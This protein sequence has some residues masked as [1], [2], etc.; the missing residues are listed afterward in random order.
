MKARIHMNI[1]LKTRH[2]S[3]FAPQ[4][5]AMI[6]VAIASLAT[7]CA[8]SQQPVEINLIQAPR[9]QQIRAGQPTTVWSYSGTA[10]K[11]TRQT[12]TP[13]PNS[14]LGPTIRVWTGQQVSINLTNLIDEPS[15]THWHGLDVPE[16]MDGHPSYAIPFGETFAYKFHVINRAGTY[17]YHPHPHMRT[18]AQVQMGLAG[19]LI[20]HDKEEEELGL[21]SGAFDVPLVIQDRTFDAN[22]QFVYNPNMM[23]GFFGDTICVNGK[24]NYVHPT[25]STVHRLR[26]LNGSNARIYKLAFTDDIPMVVIGN[27]GGLLAKPEVKPYVMLSPGER[28]E[29]WA[30]FGGKSVGTQITLRSLAFSG[31][32]LNQGQAFDVMRFQINRLVT[33]KLRLPEVL[34]KIIPYQL[35]DAVNLKNPKTYPIDMI[36]GGGQMAFRLNNRLFEMDAV[37]PNEIAVCDSLELISVTNTN[38][39]MPMAH[40]IHFHGR[41]FQIIDREVTA[42]QQANWNTV[43]DGYVDSGW[44]DTFMIMPGETVRFLVRHS[45]YPGVFLYHCHNLEHEDMGMMRNFLLVF[46]Q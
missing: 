30:D 43:K 21:P 25:A 26:L 37:E 41:Q 36:M 15:I 42:A 27:D 10:V 38:G 17:W 12:L 24:P 29:I 28:V 40:P 18:G 22:N 4:L 9:L 33:E 19:L 46:D 44:K 11:G 32:G 6:S 2:L 8:H 20:V 45:M 1:H 3:V 13:V 34:S 16:E 5:L 7:D 31:A 39:M 35:E 23:T 14:Y